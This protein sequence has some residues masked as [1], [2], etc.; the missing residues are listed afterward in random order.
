MSGSLTSS[1]AKQ[2]PFLGAGGG[3]AGGG[4]PKIVIAGGG[5]AALE[6]LLALR[7]LL[8]ARAE[9]TV[10]APNRRLAYRPAATVEAFS[11]ETPRGYD[12]AKIAADCGASFRQDRLEAVATRMRKARLASFATLPYDALV[13]AV[14]ARARVAIPGALTFCDQREVPQL[15]SM[16]TDLR[17]GRTKRLLFSV[18]VGCAWPLPLYELAMLTANEVRLH[19]LPAEVSLASY[20]HAPLEMFGV[21]ASNAVAGMLKQRGVRFI[22]GAVPRRVRGDGALELLS[23]AAIPAD[24][25]VAAPQL[26]GPRLS[27]IPHDVDGFVPVDG[28]GK[29]DGLHGVYAAGDMT[30]FPIKQ[31]G[32][33]AQQADVIAAAIAAG[34]DAPG[35]EVSAPMRRLLLRPLH[36]R[37]LGGSK[38]LTLRTMLDAAGRPLPSRGALADQ[39]H[40][41]G[42]QQRPEDSQQLPEDSQQR[43]EKVGGRY[44]GAFLAGREPLPA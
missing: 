40:P 3:H 36:A 31:G 39:Q 38:P 26:R 4:V 35:S 23:G 17:A 37:L 44:L 33:A 15:R 29:V 24:R 16:L 30:D 20:A 41:E 22:G 12:L 2:R 18:P 42:L 34:L 1:D 25:V 13:L 32:L 14:G 43:P 11:S 5:F 21:D 9:I 6:A 10:V 28:E 27:G 7:A 19:G 8:P